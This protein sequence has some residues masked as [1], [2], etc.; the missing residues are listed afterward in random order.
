MEAKEQLRDKARKILSNHYQMKRNESKGAAS[1]SY[2]AT[3]NAMLDFAQQFSSQWIPVEKE[4]VRYLI[5]V[6]TP[7]GNFIEQNIISDK[8]YAEYKFEYYKEEYNKNR[9]TMIKIPST[10]ESPTTK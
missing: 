5:E 9:V 6:H 7:S 1:N 2:D 10:K 3:I 4:N 8:E